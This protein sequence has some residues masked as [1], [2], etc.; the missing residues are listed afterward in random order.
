[1]TGNKSRHK[2]QAPPRLNQRAAGILLHPTSLPGPHGS[3]DFGPQA[4]RFAD[5][6]HAA[7]QRWW[8]VLPLG[9]VG[10]GNSP[11]STSSS[12]AGGPHL[13][14]L[15]LLAG[16]GLLSAADLRPAP[17]LETARVNYPAT[18]AYRQQRLRRAFEAFQRRRGARDAWRRFCEEQRSWLDEY[19]LFAALK[20]V[21][22]QRPW[23]EWEPQLARRRAAALRH[24]RQA[25]RAEIEYESFVQFA[26]DRQWM[27]LKRYCNQRGIGL[28]GD[29]PIFTDHDS[30][31]VWANQSLY[32]LDARG[33]PTAVSGVPPDYFSA[34]G[35]LW[36]HPLYRWE[37]HART[38]Y[39]WWISRFRAMLRRFD[40]IRID[41]FLGF[42]RLWSV[43]AGASTAARGR[44]T[45]SP[46][47]ELFAALSRALGPLPVIAE[48]LGLLTRAAAELRTRLGFPG[49]RVLQ[50]AFQAGIRYDQPHRYPRH[51]VAYTGTH[52][53]NTTRGWFRALP[54][55]GPRGPDGLS[56]RQRVLR[57]LASDGRRIER[58][59]VR[60]VYASVANLAIIPMQ[61][62]LGLD[63]SAR[64]NFPATSQGNWEWR[65]LPGA[66][67]DALARRLREL[68]ETYE[69]T[70][71]L[72]P[73][74][75][76]A[77]V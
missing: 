4:Y 47:D 13:I 73:D 1:M 43:P 36:G 49:M 31:D 74:H 42:H 59:F 61:D 56:E 52:D 26:F 69:R 44:W 17:G 2:R 34:T 37:R 23:T 8:Q 39:A 16:Q 68:A 63:A 58:D 22:G 51:C 19:T 46:G 6:L 30:C 15:Q 67:S 11:Y 28:I 72:V 24:A 70:S 71:G 76:I 77:R 27:D 14:S 57:Y 66:C 12:F 53:N 32:R 5:F 55:N 65:M 75:A 60:A 7:G 62:L 29:L 54:R 38:G 20:R 18:L 64:M 10:S 21:H 40:A 45:G 50:F 33:R 3:G 25:L 41:H 48:D 35:Q 9:P